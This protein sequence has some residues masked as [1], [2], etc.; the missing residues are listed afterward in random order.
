[1]DGEGSLSLALR[2]HRRAS[3]E[4]STRVCVYNASREV[5]E[6][7]Q[8]T[9]GGTLSAVG[10]RK[11]GWK[12]AFALIWTNAAAAELLMELAPHLRVK[13]RHASTL[14]EFQEHVWAGRR[15][16]DASGRLLHLSAGELRARRWFY[17]RM[18]W[19]NIRGTT[20]RMQ[21]RGREPSLAIGRDV[22]PRYLA[23]FIDGEGA[24][25]IARSSD[26]SHKRYQYRARIAVANVDRGVL[27]DLQG[28]F[29]GILTNQ[30]PR[31][32]RWKH[33]Y[34][35]VWTDRMAGRI[36]RAVKPYLRVKRRQ[37]E[38]LLNFIRHKA[39]TRQGHHGR[40]F[41]PL[42]RKVVSFREDL[43]RKIRKL[44]AKGCGKEVKSSRGPCGR[45]ASPAVR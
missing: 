7:I 22:S 44:N 9:W 16:R 29:G 35:L 40:F 3:P 30:P 17:E 25:M 10:Q 41:A 28:S 13:A 1:M 31:K 33:A 8:R 37:A 6:E 36:L 12:P 19:L 20:P 23:G 2:Q 11:R 21:R 43:Y 26:S 4:Y 24:L 34:G 38:V 5:L 45:I 39:R 32:T 14:L 42:P 15:T 18:K 27:E